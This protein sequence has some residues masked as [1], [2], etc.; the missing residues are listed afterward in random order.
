MAA[1]SIVC[2]HDS[3]RWK[4]TLILIEDIM[5]GGAAAL[6]F[7]KIKAT[8]CPLELLTDTKDRYIHNS[9]VPADD[10]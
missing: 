9:G 5:H 10:G 6:L 4:L 3:L 2:T 7:G 8:C 1:V